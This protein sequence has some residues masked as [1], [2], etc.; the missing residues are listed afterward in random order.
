MLGGRCG[1]IYRWV[2]AG[3]DEVWS[4]ADRDAADDAAAGNIEHQYLAVGECHETE[5]PVA[6]DGDRLGGTVQ[7]DYTCRFLYCRGCA[8]SNR[9]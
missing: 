1:T 3:D 2:K 4:T 9:S 6:G 5:L 7:M 8:Y